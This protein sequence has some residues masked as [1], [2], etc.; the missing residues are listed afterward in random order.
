VVDTSIPTIYGFP[1]RVAAGCL[2]T[3]SKN[4]KPMKCSISDAEVFCSCQNSLWASTLSMSR[5]SA[6]LNISTIDLKLPRTHDEGQF[7][8]SKAKIAF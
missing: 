4:E 1:I 8:C 5:I 2:D 6:S 7:V 3:H